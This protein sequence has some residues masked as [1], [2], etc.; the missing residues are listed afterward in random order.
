MS[1]A[2]DTYTSFT[3][4]DGATAWTFVVYGTDIERFSEH[5]RRVRLEHM[6]AATR[7]IFGLLWDIELDGDVL[8]REG[9]S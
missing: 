3:T 8:Q 1:Y 4:T 9:T 6:G 7:P 5:M 2:D